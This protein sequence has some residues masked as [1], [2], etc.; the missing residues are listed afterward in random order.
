MKV[1]PKRKQLWALSNTWEK[2]GTSQLHVFNLSNGKTVKHFHLAS[3]DVHGFNDL[4][5]DG[6]GKAYLTDTSFG[7]VYE[8]DIATEELTLIVKD[9]LTKYPNGIA[10]GN[11]QLYIA[12]YSNGIL[13]Y[14]LKKKE[15]SRVTGTRD[16]I[17]DHNLDGLVLFKNS[18][19]GIANGDSPERNMVIRYFLDPSGTR[20]VDE[21][22]IDRA[23][24]LFKIPTTLALSGQRIYVVANSNLDAYNANNQSAKGI[25]E[26]LTSPVILVYDLE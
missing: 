10:L 2:P 4:V 23:N 11:A 8:A 13:R 24:P 17:A 6:R 25:E 18:L 1:D 14:D 19:I 5:L 15:L 21:K 9:S 7:A 26:K 22:I 3:A 12:T 16:S 20:V